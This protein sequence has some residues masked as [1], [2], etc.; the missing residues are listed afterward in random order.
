MAADTDGIVEIS[1][2][3]FPL[4]TAL[5]RVLSKNGKLLFL[6]RIDFRVHDIQF[7]D[8][9]EACV[10]GAYHSE[11]E[12]ELSALEKQD[13]EKNEILVKSLFT[14]MLGH[15]NTELWKK[16][17]KHD[18]ILQEEILENY[19]ILHGPEPF[20]GYLSYLIRLKG[21]DFFIGETCP[22]APPAS[23]HF[24][25]LPSGL[26]QKHLKEV[27]QHISPLKTGD[28]PAAC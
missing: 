7:S 4:S 19:Y 15:I 20:V 13:V 11:I 14:N 23:T 16:N 22:K 24:F 9:D 6:E 21:H 3:N 28:Q 18:F 2:C 25:L 12:R 27:L 1:V 17:I 26:Y 8:Q 10:S 5:K